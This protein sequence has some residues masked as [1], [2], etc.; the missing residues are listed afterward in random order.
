MWPKVLKVKHLSNT[1]G[2]PC[3]VWLKKRIICLSL[4]LKKYIR[5]TNLY[6]WARH[7][8]ELHV[9][10]KVFDQ[11]HFKKLCV[12]RPLN[13]KQYLVSGIERET[14]LFENNLKSTIS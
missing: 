5:P 7:L 1:Q 4:H 14:S 6:N 9:K 11:L 8:I 13:H 3:F 2:Y 12:G 10:M